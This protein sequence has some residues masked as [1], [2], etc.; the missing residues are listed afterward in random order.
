MKKS[1]LI[2]LLV[3]FLAVAVGVSGCLDNENNTTNNTT[4]PINNSTENNSPENNSTNN[5]TENN[6]TN[7]STG[8]NTSN[9]TTNVTFDE[10]IVKV[11]PVP[12]GFELL[13]VKNVTS[14]TENI[15]G[16]ND[17]LAGYSATYQHNNSSTESVYLFVFQCNNST[18]A[19][20]Y[21]QKMIDAHNAKYPN[22]SN[23][24]NVTVNN[25]NATLLTTVSQGSSGS[26][27]Y[28]YVWSNNDRL[29]VV[30][31]PASKNLILSIADASGL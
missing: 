22:S 3:A 23:V 7:N 24:T 10:N 11:N 9:N 14:N 1:I 12:A 27:N 30:N 25:H 26:E 31:G 8:N 28:E 29:I 15:N 19:A 21:V 13:A 17:A 5:S 4:P 18:D 6:S 20:G 16:L 2:I